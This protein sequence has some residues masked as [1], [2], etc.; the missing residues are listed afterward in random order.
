MQTKST[1]HGTPESRVQ[2]GTVTAMGHEFGARQSVGHCRRSVPE[3][4]SG[5]LVGRRRRN[6]IERL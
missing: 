3:F 4:A 1:T 5:T 2:Q 6:R